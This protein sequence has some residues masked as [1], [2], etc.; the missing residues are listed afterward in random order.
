MPRSFRP[1]HINTDL[2]SGIGEIVEVAMAKH[3]DDRYSSTEAMLEDLKA[4]RAGR[5]P[6]HAHRAVDLD[7]LSQIEATGTAIEAPPAPNRWA[8]L[9]ANPYAIAMLSLAGVSLLFNL[10]LLLMVTHH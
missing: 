1:D 9:L 5:Q 10:I 7:S 4:V 8:E 3:R 2:S 6:I